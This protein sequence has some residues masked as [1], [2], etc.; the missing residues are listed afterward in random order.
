MEASA[1]KMTVE[2]Q[3][4]HIMQ[5]NDLSKVEPDSMD[6]QNYSHQGLGQFAE[7]YRS[8]VRTMVC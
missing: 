4:S 1:D 6:S 7:T 8:H 3:G 5:P 2:R